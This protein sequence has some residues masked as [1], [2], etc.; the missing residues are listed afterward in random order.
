MING[1]KTNFAEYL[2]SNGIDI[3]LPMVA[4]YNGAVV[5]ISFQE[6]NEQDKTVS[7]YAPVF[8]NVKYK[9][10]QPINNYIEEFITHIPDK[11]K[12]PFFRVCLI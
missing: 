7:F 11:Q 3:R 10:A 4:N 5:N 9:L 1:V 12:S 2:R 8:R 6:I